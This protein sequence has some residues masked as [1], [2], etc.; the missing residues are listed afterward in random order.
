MLAALLYSIDITIVNVALPTIQGNLGA[1]ID[2]AAWVLT[3]YIIANI[4][5]IPITPWLQRRFGRKRYFLLS[6]V[7][8]TLA[9]VLCG[10][11]KSIEVLVA[12]RA[13]QGL[14]GGGLLSTAQVIMRD[15]FAPEE[16]GTG[17]SIF[18]M[19]TV[20]GPS[21]GPTLGGLITDNFSWPW[22]FM[23][24]I[25]PGALATVLVWRYLRDNAPPQKVPVDYGGVAL[26]AMTVAGLQFVLDQGQLYDWFSDGRIVFAAV[27][28]ALGA[29]AFVW[30][31]LRTPAP[32]VDLRI[33]RFRGVVLSCLVSL[34]NGIAVFG[35]VILLPQFI[36]AELGFTET[37][38]GLLLAVRAIPVAV[39]S[40]FIGR[41]ANDKRVD[42]RILIGC[43]IGVSGLGSLWL[44]SMT[45]TA[46][47][48]GSLAIPLLFT[49]C[50]IAFV[51]S[52]LLVA[53]LR[54]APASEG[55]KASSLVILAMQLGGS[56]ASAMIV[57]FWDRRLQF[58]DSV[59][60]SSVTGASRF[61]TSFLH[62]HPPAVLSAMVLHEA[63]T[64]AYQDAFWIIGII[65]LCFAPATWLLRA[66]KVNT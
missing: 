9:S 61:V 21:I 7:G 33:F 14:F 29:V 13:L 51:Y 23:V 16:L 40:I 19:G 50:G 55:S 36:I 63:A 56:T 17:Q 34:V 10:M 5:V 65:S 2:Q 1:T 54:S 31:E 35:V 49:G 8:F 46:A 4:V 20:L 24:N 6:I 26:L 58:H 15:T 3:G 57:T 11:A 44:A 43:G 64:L 38:A 47:S 62:T 48:Y 66:G 39:L 18:S 53:A 45:S 41:L 52:P 27:V 59:L 30:H 22:V 12:F 32:V 25:V 42:L 28:A 37:L 60:S